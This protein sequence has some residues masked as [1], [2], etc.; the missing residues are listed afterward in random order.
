MKKRFLILFITLLNL[1]TSYS[2]VNG[3][4]D[5]VVL[6][7]ADDMGK[8]FIAKDYA[9]FLKYT[10][11]IVIK[12][13]GSNEKM[14]QETIKSFKQLEADNI[15]FLEVKFGAP[16]KIATVEN[17]MQCIIPQMIEMKIPGG[18]LTAHTTLIAISSN[19]GKNWYFVDASGNS[20]ENMKML[21]PTLSTELVLPP[22]QDPSFEEDPKQE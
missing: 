2:Q 19:K 16:S 12:N 10:H 8:K 17:E 6:E 7:Q 9:G 1:S 22:Q 18:K 3:D 21:L 4:M 11:P 14:L 15:T 20:H 5:R 13:M